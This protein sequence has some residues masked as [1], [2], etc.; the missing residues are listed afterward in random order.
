MRRHVHISW[1]EAI[2]RLVAAGALVVDPS[3][4]TARVDSF[5]LTCL[6]S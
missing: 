4:G 2:K 6:G 1:E 3:T 5:D